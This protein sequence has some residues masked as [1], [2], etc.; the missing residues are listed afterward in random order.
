[1]CCFSGNCLLRE[2]FAEVDTPEDV[3]QRTDMYL[4]KLPSERACDVLLESM[5]ERHMLFGKS[6]SIT[7]PTAE[8][9][10]IGSLA[11]RP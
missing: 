4:W 2:C 5:L 1:M 3:L 7:Q 11:G 10:G 9:T 8:D 6:V